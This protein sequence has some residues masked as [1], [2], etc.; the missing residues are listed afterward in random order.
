MAQRTDLTWPETHMSF[1][2]ESK[3]GNTN[4]PEPSNIAGDKPRYALII[5]GRR[6]PYQT[7]VVPFSRCT[8]IAPQGDPMLPIAKEPEFGIGIYGC[9]WHDGQLVCKRRSEVCWKEGW[10]VKVKILEV[11]ENGAKAVEWRPF[12]W[13][14]RAKTSKRVGF[15]T[16]QQ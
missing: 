15:Q 14:T 4:L 16:W 6:F 11:G 9:S 1:R 13:A 10:S 5:M 12:G 8:R 3:R 7:T 2:P